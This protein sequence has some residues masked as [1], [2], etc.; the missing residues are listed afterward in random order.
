MHCWL[1]YRL[2]RVYEGFR[3]LG[4]LG[5]YCVYAVH[6]LLLLS[7]VLRTRGAEL[8]VGLFLLGGSLK[9][10]NERGTKRPNVFRPL[11]L[12]LLSSSL[13]GQCPW[14]G[15]DLEDLAGSRT[16]TTRRT[17]LRWPSSLCSTHSEPSVS[18]RPCHGMLGREGGR[19][20]CRTRG[21]INS[22][23]PWG[24]ARQ[25][26]NCKVWDGWKCRLC[27][28]RDCCRCTSLLLRHFWLLV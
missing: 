4:C 15:A 16:K 1:P 14:G 23:R 5:C 3:V 19:A 18:A 7:P 6:R 22:P 26:L 20:L 13:P 2:L 25:A 21:L 9:D 17:L 24:Q 11:A 28:C 10:E 12:S 27:Q 8:R